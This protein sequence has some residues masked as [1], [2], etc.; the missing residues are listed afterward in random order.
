[1]F[2]WKCPN[3]SIFFFPV[4]GQHEWKQQHGLTD[5]F[6]YHLFMMDFLKLYLETAMWSIELVLPK[7]Y[8]Q[9]VWVIFTSTRSKLCRVEEKPHFRLPDKAK[10]SIDCITTLSITASQKNFALF[11][12]RKLHEDVN[13]C[14]PMR[15]GLLNV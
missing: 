4:C 1:M 15:N 9:D 6:F 13:G 11:Y 2:S 7:L 3:P 10:Q 8:I 5:S 12:K 14:P